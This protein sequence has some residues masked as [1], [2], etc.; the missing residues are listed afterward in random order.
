MADAYVAPKPWRDRA[1]TIGYISGGTEAQVF[2][3]R[4]VLS[5]LPADGKAILT[6]TKPNGTE[7]S[8]VCEELC[9]HQLSASG[10]AERTFEGQWTPTNAAITW[11]AND[12][13]AFL[14]AH[15][16]ANVKFFGELLEAIGQ[17]TTHADLLEI[18]K[19]TYGMNWNS[20]DQIR[21]RTGWLRAL[22]MVELWGQKVVRTANG[23]ALLGR[24]TLCSPE[25]TIG[26]SDNERAHPIEDAATL[27]YISGISDLDQDSLRGRRALIGYVPRGI[28]SANREADDATLTPIAAVR[29]LVELARDGVTI[30][31]FI[32]SCGQELGIS[33]SSTYSALHAL[34]HMALLEQTSLDTYS[35]T[36]NARSLIR[37]GNEKEFIAHLHATYAFFGEILRCLSSP[38]TPSQLV[39]LGRERYGYTQASNGEVRLR[40][41]FLQDAGLVSRVDWQRFRITGAGKSFVSM[42]T[43]QHEMGVSDQQD[44]ANIDAEHGTALALGLSNV[45]ADLT[46]FSSDGNASKAFEAAVSRAFRF[47]GFHTQ[48]LGGSG[49]TDVLALAELV[50]GDRYRIIIDAKSSS[51]GTVGESAVN[52]QVLGDHKKKYKA[53]YVVV[54]A[55]DFAN[56]LKNWAVDN[57]VVLLQVTDLCAILERHSINP[58]SLVDLR[59]TFA[60]VD[61]LKDEIFER[62]QLLERRSSL[63][64][65]ILEL[66][67]QEAIDED[68]IVAGFMSHENI[69]Y[70]LR[71]EFTPRPS[72]EEIREALDFLSSSFVAALE[73]NKGLYKLADS[74]HNVSLRLYGLSESLRPPEL[75]RRAD[76]LPGMLRHLRSPSTSHW[77]GPLT[78]E[79]ASCRSSSSPVDSRVACALGPLFPPTPGLTAPEAVG[80]QCV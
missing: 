57:A 61:T 9:S 48:D 21:R 77:K 13:P 62:Y 55:P 41:G 19:T 31:E 23:Q 3:L 6:W 38:A 43:L 28:N 7:A 52:F 37:S 8:A 78:C 65:K 58:I 66:V 69:T 44:D 56:R 80:R 2:V 67:F 46:K 72:T 22:N 33:K 40:L 49:Q 64:E 24:L 27:E 53:D 51:H 79:I 60:R 18:A 16:H 32:D 70:A 39:K 17:T 11:L 36:S 34:R 1:N 12:N 10:L 74:P 71:K 25:D 42:I 4:Q 73:E 29:R 14:A 68:P 47:L 20:L 50:M 75:S 45:V 54:I 35:P 5:K 63:T 26:D 15:L 76:F 30:E 59:E